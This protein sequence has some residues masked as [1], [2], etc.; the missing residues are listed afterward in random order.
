MLGRIV[1]LQQQTRLLANGPARL[2]PPLW[3]VIPISRGE[4]M[5]KE[6][7]LRIAYIKVGKAADVLQQAGEEVLAEEAETFAKKIDLAIKAIARAQ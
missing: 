5:D 7:L 1:M 2:R 3:C 4:A 6:E